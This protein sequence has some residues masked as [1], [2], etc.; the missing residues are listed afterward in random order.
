MKKSIRHLLID[1][2]KTLKEAMRQLEETGKKIL[3]VKSNRSKLFGSLTDGDI[4]RWI[5]SEGSLQDPVE[6]VCNL[7]PFFVTR[8]YGPDR[9][10]K[11]FQEKAISCVPVVNGKKEIVDLLFWED[12]FQGDREKK[13]VRRIGI[14]VVIMAGGQ[15]TRL[16]PFTRILP[17]PL[18]PI[19]DKTVVE[20]IIDRFLEFGVKKFYLTVNHKSR[21]IKSY[22]EELNPPYAIE[23]VDEEIPLGTAG[24]L[25]LLYPKVRSSLLV[26][27]CDVLVKIDY[28]ELVEHHQKNRNDLTLVASLRNYHIPYG[29][30]EIAN[31]GTLT[32]ITE[33]P[34]YS[35][36][37]NTGMYVI[38]KEALN[39][40]PSRQMFHI[41]QLIEKIKE[42]GGKIGVFPIGEEAWLDTGEWAEYKKALEKIQ[43]TLEP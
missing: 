32:K 19:G 5:L 4:R 13:P 36:L 1:K 16:D 11:E 29:I 31:G 7:A 37:V 8:N 18:I 40:I 35:F 23:Y 41:T 38:R 12:V 33:K 14:P 27:N 39:H 25:K 24:S 21:I 2:N 15:G 9:L 10:K 17:K 20:I 22:F 34:E 3:F 26:T 6:K 43:C 30:C 42:T 28:G